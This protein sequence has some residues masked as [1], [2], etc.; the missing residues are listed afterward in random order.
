MFTFFPSTLWPP[1]W[2]FKMAT[3]MKSGNISASEHHRHMTQMYKH[4]FS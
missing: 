4:T 3:V 1:S 2:I